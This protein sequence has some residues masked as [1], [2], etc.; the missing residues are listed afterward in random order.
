M[1]DPGCDW[2]D[3][4]DAEPCGKTPTQMLAIGM[5]APDVGPGE[6]GFAGEF[7]YAHFFEE[8]LPEMQR[9]LGQRKG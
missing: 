8:H 9:K 4:E 3:S 6:S 1:A 5:T 7:Q 2:K